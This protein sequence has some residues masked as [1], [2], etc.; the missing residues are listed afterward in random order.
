MGESSV[1]HAR[2]RMGLSAPNA[3]HYAHGF[4]RDS[5]CPLCNHHPEDPMNFLPQCT[6]LAASH[7]AML[8]RVKDIIEHA[9][10]HPIADSITKSLTPCC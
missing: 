6:A 2:M 5:H 8:A 3:R 4:I 9:P 7:V 10:N 1:N